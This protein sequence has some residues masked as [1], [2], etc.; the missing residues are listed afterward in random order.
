MKNFTI[1]FFFLF[2]L[3]FTIYLQ[4]GVIAQDLSAEDILN[5]SIQ[6]HDPEGQWYTSQINLDLKG[7]Y[8]SGLVVQSAIEI[9]M[10]SH[11]F[12]SRSTR[13]ERELVRKITGDS[14]F[15]S[16][17]GNVDIRP[18]EKMRLKLTC[19]QTARTRN[20]NIYLYG[21]PMKLKDESAILNPL[22]ERETLKGKEYYVIKVSYSPEVGIDI[23]RFFIHP[24]TFQMEAY[25][26]YK[27][28]KDKKGEMIFLEGLTQV[29][30]MKLPKARTWYDW[31]EEKLLGKD[32]VEKGEL[33]PNR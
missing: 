17:D 19:K 6:F 1:P 31:P 15:H 16:V 23:W 9:Y 26:F 18:E 13:S 33:I 4:P 11:N 3:F 2:L 29:G 14:C 7:E 22:V 32:I 24:K 28:E 20:Y 25:Q 10:P 30:A 12:T 5:K 21:L 8:A 27:N